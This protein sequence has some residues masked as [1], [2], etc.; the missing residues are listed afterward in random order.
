MRIIKK[1]LIL[2][3]S[4][5]GLL[6]LGYAQDIDLSAALPIDSA[7]R[8][9][10]LENG[11]TYYIRRQPHP[12]QRI[13]FRLAV[14]IGSIHE[15]DTQ[16]GM[17]HFLEHML[18]NG[19]KS[20]EKNEVIR[21]LESIGADFGSDANAYTFFDETVYMLHV[22]SEDPQ[23]V[24]QC[25]LIFKEWMH[26]ATLN[27]KEIE[28]ERGVIL[29]ENRQR[30]SASSRLV[31]KILPIVYDNAKYAQRL[32]IGTIESIENTPREE[33]VRFYKEW[34]RPDLMGFVLVGDLDPEQM[35]QKIKD[36]FSDVPLTSQPRKRETYDVDSWSETKFFAMKDKELPS[37][38]YMFFHRLER[39]AYETW[40]DYKHFLTIQLIARMFNA[41]MYE[42]TEEENAPFTDAEIGYGT[43]LGLPKL[44]GMSFGAELYE[45]RPAEGIQALHR[46]LNRVKTHGFTPGELD[47]E[48]KNVRRDIEYAYE[49]REKTESSTLADQYTNYHIQPEENSLLGIEHKYTMGLKVIESITIEDIHTTFQAAFSSQKLHGI[50]IPDKE[51]LQMLSKEEVL[52][53]AQKGASEEVTAY[54]YNY[55]EGNLLATP[56]TPGQIVDKKEIDTL[57]CWEVTFSNGVKVVLK[58]TDFK[59][60]QI[61]FRAYAPGGL[62]VVSEEETPSF[63]AITSILSQSGLAEFSR[64]DL[65]ELLAG[66][67]V[68][69]RP[70]TA[71]STHGISGSSTISDLEVALQLIYLTFTA[72]RKSEKAFQAY[73]SK[74]KSY[75]KNLESIPEY[76]LQQGMTNYS[77]NLPRRLN[78]MNLNI[79]KNVESIDLDTGLEKYRQAYANASNFTFFFVG[80]FEIEKI[81][82]LLSQYIGA[83]PATG[84]VTEYIDHEIRFKQEA[85]EKEF[86]GGEEPKSMVILASV[87]YMP[88]IYKDRVAV[89]L[90][91]KILEA[92]LFETLRE[93]KRGVYSVSTAVRV[94]KHPDFT[95]TT[96][97]YNT[98]VFFQCAPKNA[99]KLISNT[100]KEMIKIQ[101]GKIDE[102]TLQSSK[103][104]IRKDLEESQKS[105][106]YWLSVLNSTYETRTMNLKTYSI[107]EFLEA[108]DKVTETDVQYAA[109][110]YIS[111][112]KMHRYIL[113]PN[114]ESINNN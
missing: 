49:N 34:Y 50:I 102:E 52:A 84:P 85:V 67:N 97:S 93:K 37:T 11:L 32:P 51:G 76:R 3:C 81:L 61:L 1:A 101:K 45:D 94:N 40:K 13:E 35:E 44:F 7:L 71:Q 4:F 100:K 6:C 63:T 27:P 57:S 21:F 75:I 69:V 22:P 113:V 12:E 91:S 38:N 30:L 109:K 79:A 23:V 17:A 112:D 5:L 19:T 104:Q 36:I 33:I 99:E 48:K 62:S 103:E 73:I 106:N 80:S 56:P 114:P 82:P 46:E 15:D 24:D 92:R 70:Y 107:D 42:I 2:F 110:K 43:F 25:F 65:K 66:K 47:R 83:L 9:G 29:E 20:F 8:I 108:L 53:F 58:P 90:L 87:Q 86:V 39:P 88:F 89:D 14:Q 64:K 74:Q 95:P 68:S 111:L 98:I 96:A 16:R 77:Y 60:N 72:P 18:F 26:E 31:E 28:Q 10:K 55:V 59:K 41:R 105:N 78:L 54:E